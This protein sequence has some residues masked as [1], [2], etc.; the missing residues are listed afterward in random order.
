MFVNVFITNILYMLLL[1][2]VK[3]NIVQSWPVFSQL[4]VLEIKIYLKH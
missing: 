2:F 1:N 4:Q 3:K